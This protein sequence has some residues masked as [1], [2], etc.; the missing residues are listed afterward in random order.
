MATSDEDQLCAVASIEPEHDGSCNGDTRRREGF[1]RWSEARGIQ[2]SGV[3]SALLPERGLGLVATED[4]EQGRKIVLVPNKAMLKSRIH[5]SRLGDVDKLKNSSRHAQ[6]TMTLMAECDRPDSP[7]EAWAATWPS[8]LDMTACMPI[9]WDSS[10]QKMLPLATQDLLKAQIEEY[11]SDLRS[12]SELWGHDFDVNEFLYYWCI[13]STRGFHFKPPGNAPA[14]TVMCPFLDFANHGPSGSGI[15]VE[16]TRNGYE[17][18]V[19]RHY[20]ECDFFSC[21]GSDSSAD[22]GCFF[23]SIPMHSS[24]T[25]TCEMKSFRGERERPNHQYRSCTCVR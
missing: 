18:V 4:L 10:L 9:Q 3:A 23:P 11:E 15:K 5:Y 8:R 12:A 7:L 6:L 14:Y 1:V 13:V 22:D 19:D 2:I 17:A 24:S 20:G 21:L 16:Q 25:Q